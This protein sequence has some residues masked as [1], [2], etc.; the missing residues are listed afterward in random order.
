MAQSDYDGCFLLGNADLHLETRNPYLSR[1]HIRLLKNIGHNYK[2]QQAFRQINTT[3]LLQ[4]HRSP[5]RS[6]QSQ[7]PAALQSNHLVGR[8]RNP[9]TKVVTADRETKEARIQDNTCVIDKDRTFMQ[10]FLFKDISK[11]RVDLRKLP[12]AMQSWSYLECQV[13]QCRPALSNDSQG[14]WTELPCT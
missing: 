2:P 3:R 4:C 11:Q 14:C 13:A 10:L 9:L 7:N 5:A 6:I 12:T 8:C 1:T